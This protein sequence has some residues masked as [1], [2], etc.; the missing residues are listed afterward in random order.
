MLDGGKSARRDASR[1]EQ[2]L[3]ARVC[4][5]SPDTSWR[6]PRLPSSLRLHLPFASPLTATS[7]S[8]SLYAPARSCSRRRA[9]VR[10]HL[11]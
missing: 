4:S 1:Q 10:L 6:M 9:H 3:H 5:A 8:L 11:A 2:Q 7:F